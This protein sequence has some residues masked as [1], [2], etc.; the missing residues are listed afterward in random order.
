[1]ANFVITKNNNLANT[2]L[3]LFNLSKL[4]SKNQELIKSNCGTK[5][6]DTKHFEIA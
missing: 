1:M 5:K 2:S 6:N 4:K 3:Y